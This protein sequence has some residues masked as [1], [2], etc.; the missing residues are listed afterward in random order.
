L[1]QVYDGILKGV[2]EQPPLKQ[3][4]FHYAMSISRERNNLL[5]FGKPVS[6]WL[7]FKHRMADK[8]VLSKIRDKLGGR[9]KYVLNCYIH[10]NAH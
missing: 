7:A 10:R 2:S 3:K 4:I 6:A 8:V 5:E 1:A 9:L